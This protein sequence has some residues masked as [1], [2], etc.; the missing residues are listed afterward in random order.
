MVGLQKI[1]KKVT[2]L[3]STEAAG[4]LYYS[5]TLDYNVIWNTL[6]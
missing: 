4:D 6:N 5:G 3:E 2:Q 1:L